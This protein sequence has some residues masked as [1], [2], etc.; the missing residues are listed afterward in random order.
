MV[1]FLIVPAP[2]PS[3]DV[4]LPVNP[5]FSSRRELLKGCTFFI[6]LVG[7]LS[8]CNGSLLLIGGKPEGRAVLLFSASLWLVWIAIR[9]VGKFR[10]SAR[11]AQP[12]GHIRLTSSAIAIPG[13][14]GAIETL[15]WMD[16]KEV[17]L[18]RDIT[19]TAYYEFY[20][21]EENPAMFLER[22]RVQDPQ[23][24]EDELESRVAKFERTFEWERPAS[25]LRTGKGAKEV[26]PG[27]RFELTLPATGRHTL[28]GC[29]GMILVFIIILG[30]S[31][32]FPDVAMRWMKS[33]AGTMIVIALFLLA[34]FLATRSRKSWIVCGVE[35]LHTRAPATSFPQFIRWSDILDY[36]FISTGGKNP[37]RIVTV[38][39]PDG[40]W[41]LER[42]RIANE[43]GLRSILGKRSARVPRSFMER[44]GIQQ[45]SAPFSQIPG[46]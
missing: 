4:V 6:A 37:S 10:E 3:S 13:L 45:H 33:G 1:T 20:S 12:S 7:V 36:T 19:G 44:S 11:T 31:L 40:S 24:L 25:S 35:G 14:M 16:V 46:S 28:Q 26:P 38:W 17:R 22:S 21:E 34:I 2:G 32:R 5:E 39:T 23:R 18:T 9:L 15:R 41:K 29:G 43:S 30:F 8:A 42:V 27:E